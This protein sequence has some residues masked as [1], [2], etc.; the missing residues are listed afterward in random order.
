MK[1]FIAFFAA[2][3][4]V[5]SNVSA[6]TTEQRI[7]DATKIAVDNS[8]KKHGMDN[9][10]CASVFNIALDAAR[11]AVISDKPANSIVTPAL[12]K[13]VSFC[14][15]LGYTLTKCTDMTMDMFGI[16][17]DV[18]E[19]IIQQDILEQQKGQSL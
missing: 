9:A 8:C 13:S 19:I 11:D 6:A 15:N 1:I 10:I 4:F 3:F 5:I 12:M 18:I 2:M 16:S 17:F 7:V 14:K